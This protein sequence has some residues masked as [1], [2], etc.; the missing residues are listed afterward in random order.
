MVQLFFS[1]SGE[2]ETHSV[3]LDSVTPRTLQSMEL[4][5]SEY[6]RVRIP[7]P[8][9]G[10]LPNPGIKPR[11]PILQVYSLPAEP[12]GKPKNARAGSLSFLQGIFLTQELNQG[13]LHCRWIPY[14]LSSQGSPLATLISWQHKIVPKSDPGF[15]FLICL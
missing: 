8:S 6:W 13:L 10:D 12:Q 15:K 14:Q 3:M 9:P 2:N 5:G 4:S 7:F 11:S 1:F